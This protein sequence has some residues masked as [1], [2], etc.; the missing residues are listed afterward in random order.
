[1]NDSHVSKYKI[2]IIK[3]SFLFVDKET[4]NGLAVECEETDQT[5]SIKT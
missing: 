5:P 4:T 3:C 2:I 1:M